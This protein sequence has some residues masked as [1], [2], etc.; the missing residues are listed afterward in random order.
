MKTRYSADRVR[1]KTMTTEDLRESFLLSGL[2]NENKLI[3]EYCEI[4]RAVVGGCVPVSDPIKLEAGKELAA[5][6]FCE[7]REAGVLNIGGAGK[8]TVDGEVF[9]MGKPDCLYIGRGSKEVSFESKDAKSPAI[10]YILSYPA[11]S[12]YPTKHAR[13]K[14]AEPVNLGSREE[15]NIRTIYK[16]IHPQGIKSCQLVM[17]V[18][19][20][21]KGSV[22][23]TMPAHTH[24]RR[25]EVYLY[26]DLSENMTLFHMMGPSD[27]TRHIIVHDKEAVVSPMWSIHSGVGTMAYA[28]CWGM[29][30]ENQEFTDM[31]HVEIKELK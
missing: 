4:E 6:Y 10:F 12:D 8:I 19:V 22:W 3:L 11:H 16:Y 21:S 27:E 7:R 30:G 15:A 9:E 25:T 28:F 18:T 5:N 29:G 13:Q 1:Y 24:E 26:F 20:L 17:G 2:F 23:N 14:D 31:D